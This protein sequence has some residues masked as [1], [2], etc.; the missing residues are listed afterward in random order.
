MKRN[1]KYNNG[2][3]YPCCSSDVVVET[4]LSDSEIKNGL[5]MDGDSFFCEGCC[6]ISDAMVVVDDHEAYLSGEY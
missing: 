1:V 3:T 4:S 6:E 2:L 5:Y